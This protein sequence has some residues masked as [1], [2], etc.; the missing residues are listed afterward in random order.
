[1]KTQPVQDHACATSWPT[2][3]R[4]MM[5]MRAHDG[6]PP[7]STCMAMPGCRAS[8]RACTCY[9][10][11][12]H[13]RSRAPVGSAPR[14]SSSSSRRA[15]RMTTGTD[16]SEQLGKLIREGASQADA[17]KFRL[18]MEACTAVCA[19][20]VDHECGRRETR[21]RDCR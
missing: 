18:I 8:S 2:R 3:G 1:M 20:D 15:T 14:T 19:I 13:P 17:A 5:P 4:A 10:H 21:P 7:M 16:R 6:A 12:G 11:N 9:H